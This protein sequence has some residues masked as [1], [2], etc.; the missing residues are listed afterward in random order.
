VTDVPDLPDEFTDEGELERYLKN[1]RD[2][3][4]SLEAHSEESKQRKLEMKQTVSNLE[5]WA[6]Q[7]TRESRSA[8]SLLEAIEKLRQR[9]EEFAQEYLSEDSDYGLSS[10]S[11]TT[12]KLSEALGYDITQDVE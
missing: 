4:E 12:E 6:S 7:L 5:Q 8:D 9:T 1:L 3:I 10:D 2:H 11:E